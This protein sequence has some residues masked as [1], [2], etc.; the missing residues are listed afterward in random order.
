MD[1]EKLKVLIGHLEGSS[2]RK[3]V[4]KQ[5]DLE[6]HLEKGEELAPMLPPHY[7]P[8]PPVAAPQIVHAALPPASAKE[9]IAAE[10]APVGQTVQSPMVGT[11]YAGPAPDQ[12]PFVKV[13]DKVSPDSVVC[14][15]EA[16][17]VLNEVKAGVSGTVAEALVANGQPVEFGT[18]LFR[19]V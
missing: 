8:H 10:A 11:F 3:M 18:P 14:I 5:G 13:G 12:P 15:I 7:F 2:L 9:P 19:I 16:M 4:Y 1:L 17:K 6:I